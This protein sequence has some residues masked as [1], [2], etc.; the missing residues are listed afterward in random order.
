MLIL[1][2]LS[3]PVAIHIKSMILIH[4][5][6]AAIP[7][8]VILFVSHL[9]YIFSVSCKHNFFPISLNSSQISLGGTDSDTFI[10]GTPGAIPLK[11]MGP[12]KK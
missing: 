3:V 11:P 12:L 8:G 1:R 7:Q 5:T 6:A 9:F 4:R 10:V 2:N